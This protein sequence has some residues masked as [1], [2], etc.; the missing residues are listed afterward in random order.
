M[1]KILEKLVKE[2]NNGNYDEW[3]KKYIQDINAP[4]KIRENDIILDEVLNPVIDFL[5][6][7]IIEIEEKK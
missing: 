2:I 6:C 1:K 7:R 4:H 3:A 5:N